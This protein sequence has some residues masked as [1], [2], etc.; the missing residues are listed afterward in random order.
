MYGCFPFLLLHE[1]F[2]FGFG[3]EDKGEE[4]DDEDHGNHVGGVSDAVACSE[5]AE[6][7]GCEGGDKARRI[8]TESGAGGA[9]PGGEEFGEVDGISAKNR[10]ECESH[11]E[12]ENHCRGERIGE[13]KG[14]G[15]NDETAEEG[16]GEC[17]AASQTA[18]HIA[19]EESAQEAPEILTHEG[20]AYFLFRDGFQSG[21]SFGIEDFTEQFTGPDADAPESDN[22][23]GREEYAHYCIAQ[24]GLIGKET[25]HIAHAETGAFGFRAGLHP[26]FWFVDEEEDDDHKE[27]GNDA[28]E[29]E[30]TPAFR[31]GNNGRHG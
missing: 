29:K 23:H 14:A 7:R 12:E 21:E 19:I 26:A 22:P 4:A 24:E 28:D 18:G 2:A 5:S 25:E 30:P 8:V 6:N 13:E 31:G 20:I 3:G 9:K 17:G 11:E 27:G 16:N 15:D 1:G 10:E